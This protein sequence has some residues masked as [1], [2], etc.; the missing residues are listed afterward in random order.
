MSAL[1]RFTLLLL[2]RAASRILYRF[3]LSWVGGEPA[4]PWR[5]VRVIAVLHHTSLYEPILSAVVP[6][7]VLWRLARHGVVPI[8]DKTL[9]KASLGWI[10]RYAGNRVVSV[11]RKRDATWDEVLRHFE[12][13]EAITVIFPEGRMMRPDGRDSEGQEMT[14]RG[15]VAD[16]IAGVRTGRMMLAYSGGLH[17]V[18]A[19][20]ERFPR[21]FRRIA[22]RLEEVDIPAYR[23]SLGGTVDREAFKRRVVDDL[24]RRR[25]EH[26]PLT[27]PNRPSWAA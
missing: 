19:P 15:G 12:D 11:S 17:Q 26:C 22:L 4:R 5:D 7:R 10:F 3:D 13:P 18:A 21:L 24:T 9:E 23:E 14:V 6:T 20:G 16:L 8:A 25:N 1:F 27:G 2:V